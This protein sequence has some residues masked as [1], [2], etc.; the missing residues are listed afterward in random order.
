MFAVLLA[1]TALRLGKFAVSDFYVP[2]EQL[3]MALR[4]GAAGWSSGEAKAYVRVN[5]AGF[6]D[7]EHALEK[8]PGVTRVAVLG[9]SFCEAMQLPWDRTFCA[10]L[11]KELPNVEVLNFGVSGYGT[12][13]ELILLRHKVTAY[14]PD[15]VILAFFTGNDI[16]NN[17]RRLEPNALRPFYRLQNGAMILDDSFRDHADFK[18]RRGGIARAYRA[19]KSHSRVLQLLSDTA[20]ALR[21]SGPRDKPADAQVLGLN[22]DIYKPP[23]TPDWQEAWQVSEALILAMRDE[24]QSAGARFALVLLSNPIQA[25]PDETKRERFRR[26]HGIENLFYPDERLQDFARQRDIPCIA[27]APVFQQDARQHSQHL[28]GFEGS[29][30]GPGIGHWNSSG[31]ALAAKTVAGFLREQHLL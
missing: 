30:W 11:E 1:E 4:P 25:H 10:L 7:R 29:P 16:V 27:L 9:D 2:D 13:Q 12:A 23:A 3:G 14:K 6:R 26:D 18:R 28:H 21:R 22:P 20:N 8:T 24:A 15:L 5:S 17:S 31:H 19:V